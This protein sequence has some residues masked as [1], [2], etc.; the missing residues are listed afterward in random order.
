MARLRGAS[1]LLQ[2]LAVLAAARM[3]PCTNTLA[4]LPLAPS[5]NADQNGKL[6]S[7]G[8]NYFSIRMLR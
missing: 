8:S 4:D 5:G 7:V 1:A 6:V 2:H 3:L